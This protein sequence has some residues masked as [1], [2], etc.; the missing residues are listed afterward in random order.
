MTPNSIGILC[1]LVA[2]FIF[3]GY[4]LL[5]RVLAKKS[6][7]PLAFSCIY[8]FSGAIMAGLIFIF[9]PHEPLA[10]T[11][12]IVYTTILSTI[13]YG[14]FEMVQFF[15]Y[16][17]IEA[18]RRTIIS[19][20]TPLTTFVAS[21]ILLGEHTTAIK[22]TGVILILFGNVIALY[23]QTGSNT[24]KGLRLMI[25]GAVALGL[26]YVA[27]KFAAPHYPIM[28]YEVIAYGIPGIYAL[29][30]ASL[31]RKNIIGNIRREIQ[32]NGWRI[33]LLS[34]IS[35]TGYYFMLK[36]FL[37]T[38]VSVAAPVIFTATILTV[39]GGI[40]LLRERSSIT[41]KVIGAI[42]VFIGVVLIR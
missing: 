6:E 4:N 25:F 22:I 37:L 1:A 24:N 16:K 8:A 11:R 17:Y 15:T 10:L 39:L 30:I 3:T 27:D 21:V 13:G 42:A 18:S 31:I 5:S 19:Q 12:S 14:I 26:T 7:D 38:D 36:S 32:L 28:L 29:I 23:K 9:Q 2:A 41:Q 33:P 40:I 35:I 34:A 20:I